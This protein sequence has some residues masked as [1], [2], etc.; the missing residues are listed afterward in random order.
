MPGGPKI[1]GSRRSPLLIG[2]HLGRSLRTPLPES[3]FGWAANV[4]LVCDGRFSVWRV[5]KRGGSDV[6]SAM[7]PAGE[8]D[9]KKKKKKKSKDGKK[10]NGKK[11]KTKREREETGRE[12][13]RAKKKRVES[14]T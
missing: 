2:G 13:K 1:R 4:E 6:S 11:I 14:V 10:E 9:E 3:G 7:A 5:I 12:A 8:V